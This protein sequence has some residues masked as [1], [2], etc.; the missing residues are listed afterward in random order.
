MIAVAGH[1]A[2]GGEREGGALL[3]VPGAHAASVLG[4]LA[5]LPDIVR[6]V[7]HPSPDRLPGCD[8]AG[9]VLVVDRSHHRPQFL[10]RHPPQLR[11]R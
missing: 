5:A 3:H 8:R 2:G 4:P 7:L 9:G 11:E 1:G 6:H 10:R